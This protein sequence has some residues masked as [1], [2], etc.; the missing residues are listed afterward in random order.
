MN[1]LACMVRLHRSR[2]ITSGS[3]CSACSSDLVRSARPQTRSVLSPS[4]PGSYP[5]VLVPSLDVD[6]PADPH[7]A[8]HPLSLDAEHYAYPPVSIPSPDVNSIAKPPIRSAD[9]A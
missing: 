4:Q 3:P 6:P 1:P 8:C 2:R 7:D 9:V 5:L